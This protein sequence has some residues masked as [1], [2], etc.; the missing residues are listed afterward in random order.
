[1]K[2]YFNIRTV[3]ASNI[4]DAMKNVN[5]QNFD[6]QHPLCDKILTLKGLFIEVCKLIRKSF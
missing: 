5:N 2:L 4:N 6:E 3:K 1:M